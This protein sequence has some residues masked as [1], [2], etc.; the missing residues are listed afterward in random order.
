M[1]K[2]TQDQWFEGEYF[3]S[4][5]KTDLVFP[6]FARLAD[7]MGF[8]YYSVD[9]DSRVVE[10]VERVSRDKKSLIFEVFI[11][12]TARVVPIVKFGNPNHI[13]EPILAN[14]D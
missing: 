14:M 4:D 13:M 8:A 10:T 11:Q 3:A 7:A 6:N 1:I 5:S 12:E 2:Q 9:S